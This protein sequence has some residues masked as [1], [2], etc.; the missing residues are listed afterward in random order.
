M[1]Q[2][3]PTRR[4]SEAIEAFAAERAP[5]LVAEA[6][7]AAVS[8]ARMMLTEALA[9]SLLANS[10]SVLRSDDRPSGRPAAARDG[11]S[12]GTDRT[13]VGR[14]PVSPP[15]RPADPK[16]R[17]TISSER[18]RTTS[19]DEAARDALGQYVYGITLT[20]PG[21]PDELPGVDPE[22]SVTFIAEQ[23]LAAIV[24]P[25]SLADFGD[26]R[27]RENLNDV[28][29]LESK[30]RAHEDVLDAALQRGTVVPMRL[31][32]IYSGE[33]QVREMLRSERDALLDALRRLEG[34]SEWGVKLIAELGALER[35]ATERAGVD[36]DG[37][38]A[39]PGAAY[40]DRKRRLAR[41]REEEMELADDWADA[42]HDQLAAAAC[43]ALM[44]PL[45][46]PDVSGYE[47]DMLLNGVYLVEDHRLEE[48][49]DLVDRLRDE[50]RAV[51]AA[52]DLTG[53]WPAYNFVKSSIEA[54]R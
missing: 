50:Y 40:M 35:S 21:L 42:V 16:Q 49:R 9:E 14:R 30:A 13:R 47:G 39:S 38:D 36:H 11:A 52:V 24:S 31:C 10:A 3:E 1:S 29:W 32:T 7:A 34:K 6:R 26:E 37:P 23:D 43:D 28:S 54:A 25:V 8:K 5:E 53:P 18:H 22:F 45:Q 4:L 2:D 20:P 17:R 27:L 19:S 12:E 46:R 41:S 51:G 44:N 33:E 48:F 15:P